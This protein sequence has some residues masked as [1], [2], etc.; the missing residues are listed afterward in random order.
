[1]TT[2]LHIN[3]SGTLTGSVSRAATAK[4]LEGLTPTRVITRDLAE[5]PLP[6]V[7]ET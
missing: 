4:L 2:V 6:Q 1:M 5:T 3:A 7:D